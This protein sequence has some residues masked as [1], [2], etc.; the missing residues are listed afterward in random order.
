[1]KQREKQIAKDAQQTELEVQQFQLQKQAALNQISVVVPLKI[2]QLYM[3]EKSGRL[4][5]PTDK[6]SATADDEN[7]ELQ[8]EIENLLNVEER[9][10]VTDIDMKSHVLF[11][12]K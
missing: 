5:G 2:S 4:T 1:L 11:T 8:K 12:R 3:F 7:A 10:L 6:V 9:K